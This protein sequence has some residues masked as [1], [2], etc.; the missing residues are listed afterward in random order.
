MD[1]NNS[2]PKNILHPLTFEVISHRY[3]TRA[4]NIILEAFPNTELPMNNE[5]RTYKYGQFGYGKFVYNKQDI[6]EIKYFFS[7]EIESIFHNKI[8]KYII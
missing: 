2:L 1:L 6:E 8:I 7:N 4:K 3:T 5:D